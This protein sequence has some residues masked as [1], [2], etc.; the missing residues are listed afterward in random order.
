MEEICREI[1]ADSLEFLS[2]DGLIASI[3]GDNQDDPKGGLC[4]ACF[5]HDY[6]TR[7]DF[8]GEEKFG[9]SC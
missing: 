7:L 4:L 3:Q 9:C 1:N 2:P 6:P 8:N 5:D